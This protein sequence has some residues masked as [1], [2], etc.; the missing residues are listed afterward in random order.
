MASLEGELETLHMLLALLEKAAFAQ[1]WHYTAFAAI[2]VLVWDYLLTFNDEL[3]FFWRG[4]KSW[5]AALFFLNRYLPI[6]AMGFNA[7]GTSSAL[8]RPCNPT[9]A[10]AIPLQRT[11]CLLPAT[12]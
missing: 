6:L 10:D 2:T 8:S 5:P 1:A 11:S 12:L 4:R 9:I 3:N 7:V